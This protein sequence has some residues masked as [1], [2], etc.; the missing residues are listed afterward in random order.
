PASTL[1][2]WEPMTVAPRFSVIVISSVRS[3][4]LCAKPLIVT[5]SPEQAEPGAE[6]VTLSTQGGDLHKVEQLLVT[7]AVV[8]HTFLP[9]AETFHCVG[10]PGGQLKGK[11]GGTWAWRPGARLLAM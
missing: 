9:T 7:G 2:E 10:C 1:E 8:P 6:Q 3:P 4:Q 5:W 11:R